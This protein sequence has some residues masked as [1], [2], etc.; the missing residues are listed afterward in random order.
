MF[1]LEICGFKKILQPLRITNRNTEKI[2]QKYPY[3]KNI[4]YLFLK[5]EINLLGELYKTK[6]KNFNKNKIFINLKL[7]KFHK[8]LKYNNENTYEI[9][10]NFNFDNISAEEKKLF[11]YILINSILYKNKVNIL[12][13]KKIKI[14][15]ENIKEEKNK[16]LKKLKNEYKVLK[17]KANNYLLLLN[18]VKSIKLYDTKIKITNK[19]YKNNIKMI[20]NIKKR[21]LFFIEKIESYNIESLENELVQYLNKINLKSKPIYF[22]DKEI[23]K[24]KKIKDEILTNYPHKLEKCY[25]IIDNELNNI[26][27]EKLAKFF[28]KKLNTNQ[29]ILKLFNYFDIYDFSAL[30]ELFKVK[31]NEN[32]SVF[33][34][35]LIQLKQQLQNNNFIIF[36]H[37]SKIE[38]Y[39]NIKEIINKIMKYH[40]LID[41]L[42]LE[43]EKYNKLWEKQQEFLGKINEII[44]KLNL[45]EKITFE[46][47]EEK[48]SL[49]KENFKEYTELLKQIINKRNNKLKLLNKQIENIQIE[50]EKLDNITLDSIILKLPHNYI[51][52][53]ETLFFIENN[54][55]IPVEELES[56]ENEIYNSIKNYNIQ[57]IE[58]I[59]KY[60]DIYIMI[61]IL[62]KKIKILKKKDNNDN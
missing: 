30:Y 21:I 22:T 2:L 52:D 20:N 8:Q 37:N 43:I 17:E 38:D 6:I 58:K 16:N 25:L 23:N 42:H 14:F 31:E 46:N 19:E 51:V 62:D 33:N 28:N 32:K 53:N 60:K 18:E 57:I 11:N 61:E 48:Y 29:E 10:A 26:L 3:L 41:N 7:D 1:E 34:K 4:I 12:D 9:S 39:K 47:F 44:V 15:I 36:N 27:K 55:Q 49:F 24:I 50:L 56:I 54:Y 5:N 59:N 40:K 35:N 13:L 45:K